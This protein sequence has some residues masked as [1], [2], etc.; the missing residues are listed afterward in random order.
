MPKP[1]GKSRSKGASELE[2]DYFSRKYGK[3]HRP[4]FRRVKGWAGEQGA[5]FVRD[6]GWEETK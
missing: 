1:E 2:D 5:E 3:E 6:N 4:R